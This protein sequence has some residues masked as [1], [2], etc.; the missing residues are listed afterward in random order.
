MDESSQG[1]RHDRSVHGDELRDRSALH[2]TRRSDA[3]VGAL[4]LFKLIDLHVPLLLDVHVVLDNLS[5]HKTPLVHRWLLRHRKSLLH[6]RIRL[7]RCCF[8]RPRILRC[9]ILRC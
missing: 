3:G 9:P 7:L 2:D 1:Q 8:H 4:A 6:R 5:A